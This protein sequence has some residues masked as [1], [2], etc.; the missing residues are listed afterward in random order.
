MRRKKQVLTRI[1]SNSLKIIK[2]LDRFSYQLYYQLFNMETSSI[3]KRELH[4][5]CNPH[6]TL[7]FDLNLR[8]IYYNFDYQTKGTEVSDFYVHSEVKI[9]RVRFKPGYQRI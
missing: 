2:G 4:N 9:P 5:R 6:S 1:L 8:N 3:L 7:T